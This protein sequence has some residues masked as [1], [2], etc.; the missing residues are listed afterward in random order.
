MRGFSMPYIQKPF[1]AMA[2]IHYKNASGE[3][4][5]TRKSDI[6]DKNKSL[7]KYYQEQNQVN[8]DA[9]LKSKRQIA[10]GSR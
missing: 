7:K 1:I 3:S 10:Q 4:R 9:I 2:F 6:I 5:S 8:A